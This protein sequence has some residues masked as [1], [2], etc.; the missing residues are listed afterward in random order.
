MLCHYFLDPTRTNY[1]IYIFKT[2]L[3]TG[4]IN[5][6]LAKTVQLFWIM[7]DFFSLV[8]IKVSFYYK[9]NLWAGRYFYIAVPQKAKWN[10]NKATELDSEEKE[11]A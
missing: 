5:V 7:A 8:V 10:Y 6:Y 11:L 4:E 1:F 3:A 2:F 9:R